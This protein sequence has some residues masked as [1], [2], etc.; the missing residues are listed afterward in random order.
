MKELPPSD[1]YERELYYMPYKDSINAILNYI[2]SNTPK[3]GSVLDLMCGPGYLLGE[4]R[5]KRPDLKLSGVDIDK[6][7][8]THAKKKY[9]NIHFEVGD[10]LIWTPEKK[11]DVVLCTG[12]IHH[13]EYKKQED[14]VKRIPSMISLGGFSILSDCHINDYKNE[15][16]RK[17][18]AA[19]LGYEY[20]IATIKNGADEEVIEATVDILNNDVL[21]NEYKTSI[22]KRLPIYKKYFPKVKVNK[23][24][25]KNK[26]EG[27]GDYWV[28]CEV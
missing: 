13:I 23:T 8:I 9:P 16:E 2:I 1:V 25:P 5:K 4:I 26:E 20:L 18:A 7:Y 3:N 27:Y 14:F 24:W 15:I 19:K 11:F 17:I 6:R 10:V 28:I 12:S 21:M 22:K